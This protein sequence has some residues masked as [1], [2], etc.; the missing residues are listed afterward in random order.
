MNSHQI[1]GSFRRCRLN[2]WTLQTQL[3]RNHPKSMFSLSFLANCCCSSRRS[4]DQKH[5]SKGRLWWEWF[6]CVGGW[7][8]SRPSVATLLHSA[9]ATRCD[10]QTY[11]IPRLYTSE[12]VYRRRARIWVNARVCLHQ[13]STQSARS[14]ERLTV[15]GCEIDGHSEVYLGSEETKETMISSAYCIVQRKER[16]A[17]LN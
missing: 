14:E 1:Q 11:Y 4:F 13:R 2:Q 6:W 7:P 10:G 5:N 15:G 3:P 9:S 17:Q 12:Y 8:S 16:H